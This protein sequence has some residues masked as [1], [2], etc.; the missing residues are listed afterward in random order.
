ME[1]PS[2]TKPWTSSFPPLAT[3]LHSYLVNE[4]LQF[5]LYLE[6]GVVFVT[7]DED[8]FRPL[9]HPNVHRRHC[10]TSVTTITW[11]IRL[12][13]NRAKEVQSENSV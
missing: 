10:A 9:F 12:G 8:G 13:Y 1:P 7:G 3:R 11:T 2:S 6:D 5:I 4:R